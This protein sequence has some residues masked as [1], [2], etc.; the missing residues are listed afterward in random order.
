AALGE[1][2]W[3][4]DQHVAGQVGGVQEEDQLGS[5][6]EARDVAVVACERREELEGLA[7]ELEQAA[8]DRLPARTARLCRAGHAHASLG[9]DWAIL[10]RREL[11]LRT[12]GSKPATPSSTE[13]ATAQPTPRTRAQIEVVTLG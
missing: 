1:I 5:E 8:D 6:V 4:G 3:V 10:R 9:E 2:P 11:P 13:I 7:A 12:I